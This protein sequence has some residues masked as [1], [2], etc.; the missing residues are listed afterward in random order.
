MSMDLLVFGTFGL[1]F[2]TLMV[3]SWFKYLS[4]EEQKVYYNVEE[5]QL[6][7]AEYSKHVYI[8]VL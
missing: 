8:G 5:D 4:H 3:Y 2:Y 7:V 1:V 6:I